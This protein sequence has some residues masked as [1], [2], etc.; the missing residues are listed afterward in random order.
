VALLGA[1]VGTTP[2]GEVPSSLAWP[3]ARELKLETGRDW[4]LL[5]RFPENL[6]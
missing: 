4:A 5:L 6:G 1:S 3:V 2:C